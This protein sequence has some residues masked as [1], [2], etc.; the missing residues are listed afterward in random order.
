MKRVLLV[1]TVT[2]ALLVPAASAQAVDPILFVHGWSSSGSVWSTIIGRF[3]ADGWTSSR[4]NNWSYNT[5]QSNATTASQLATRVSQIKA[6][7]GVARVDIVTHSMGGLS[8]RYYLRNL[9]GTTSVDDWVSLGGP[10]HGTN[11]AYFCFQASCVQ[12]R[13]GSSFLNSL[14]SGDETPG[15]VQYGTWWSPCDEV[16]NPDTS[17]VL[18]GATNIQTGCI[19]HSAHLTSGT[20]Y[21][22]V[23]EFVR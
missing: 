13:P 12:M 6:A 3:A 17:T 9:G 14:N 8:S 21:A 18:S 22:Q 7:T 1:L 15:A 10:N 11:W 19:S 23:R 5:S 2:S 16:I 20:V 4:L